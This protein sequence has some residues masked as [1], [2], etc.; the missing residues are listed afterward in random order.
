VIESIKLAVDGSKIAV[1][2]VKTSQ[3]RG[4]LYKYLKGTADRRKI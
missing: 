3:N 2:E 4:A 1:Q